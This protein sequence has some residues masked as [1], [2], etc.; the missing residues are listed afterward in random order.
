M[1]AKLWKKILFAICVIACLFN[2]TSK[3]VNRTSLEVNLKSVQNGESLTQIF[4]DKKNAIQDKFTKNNDSSV[5]SEE[6]AM[7]QVEEDRPTDSNSEKQTDFVV[8]Y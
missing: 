4:K 2:I 3:I 8:I 7:N 6:K 5:S 1:L